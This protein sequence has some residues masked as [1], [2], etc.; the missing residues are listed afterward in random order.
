M[1]N[2]DQYRFLYILDGSDDVT[3]TVVVGGEEQNCQVFLDCSVFEQVAADP[4]RRTVCVGVD[5]APFAFDEF[6]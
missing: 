6:G 4:P 1:P 5:A 3:P 2:L